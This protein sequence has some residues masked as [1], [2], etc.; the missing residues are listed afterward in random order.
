MFAYKCV[1]YLYVCIYSWEVVSVFGSIY[2]S[3]LIIEVSTF[4]TAYI[5]SLCKIEPKYICI[6]IRISETLFVSHR[7]AKL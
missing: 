3:V 2:T 5:M 1:D 7:V 4:P 6:Y